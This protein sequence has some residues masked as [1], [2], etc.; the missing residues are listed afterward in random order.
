MSSIPYSR[1]LI[2]PVPWYSFLIVTGIILAI[3]LSY[4][5]ER[6]MN[7]PKDTIIDLVLRLLPFGII[8]ARLYYVFFSWDQFRSDLLS[9]FRIWEGGIAIYGGIIAG[10]IVLVLFCRK[11]RLPTLML[12]DII[13]PGLVLAQSIGRWGN[14]F[15]IEAYG[16]KVT[17]PELCFFPLALQ[18]PSDGYGWHLATFFYESVWDL[19]IFLF[20][21]IAR[22]RMLR[23][24]GDVFFFYIFLYAAGRLVIEEM[25]SDSLYAA[26]SVRISQLISVILCLAVLLKY[27]VRYIRNR[28][29][30]QPAR[31]LVFLSS[32]VATSFVFLYAVFGFLP[33]SRSPSVII[34][35]LS[36]YSLLMILSLFIFYDYSPEREVFCDANNQA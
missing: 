8:G 28:R 13:A 34:L 11:R 31:L 5:E 22:R 3:L 9:V 10:I 16:W 6:R 18:V 2:G 1:Y 23:R 12:C 35:S 32:I 33:Y 20:L 25:R 21:V 7:L 17:R 27:V 19:S 24:T 4:H 29:L 36:L 30:L 26:S 15:N 14:W